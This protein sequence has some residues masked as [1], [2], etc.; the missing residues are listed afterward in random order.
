MNGYTR[1]PK[2]MKLIMMNLIFNKAYSKKDVALKFGVRSDTL[3]EWIQK[4]KKFGPDAFNISQS[5][6]RTF[7]NKLKLQ[8]VKDIQDGI[9]IKKL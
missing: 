1:F 3:K 6:R 2:K 7:P 5:S 8:T 9:V 4:F